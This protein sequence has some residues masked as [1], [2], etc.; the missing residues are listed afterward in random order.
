ML[1]KLTLARVP[2]SSLRLFLQRG[3][4][5]TVRTHAFSAA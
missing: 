1:T 4:V 2:G 3:T 5:S